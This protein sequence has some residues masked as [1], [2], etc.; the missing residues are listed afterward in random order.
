MSAAV[1]RGERARGRPFKVKAAP[2]AVATA[3]SR[4]RWFVTS[5]LAEPRTVDGCSE[6]SPASLV[7]AKRMGSTVTACGIRATTWPK[8][9][10]LP[11]PLPGRVVCAGCVAAIR[12]AG[13]HH[14]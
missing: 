11:F 3:A 10:A 13:G 1:F 7:H 2:G 9:F 4:N 12:E 8:F 14:P 5:Q 6:E